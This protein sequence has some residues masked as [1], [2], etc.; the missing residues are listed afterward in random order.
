MVRL[1]ISRNGFALTDFC[2][3]V[4]GVMFWV[5]ELNKAEPTQLLVVLSA[6]AS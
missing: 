5:T 6:D 2:S 1:V 3:V 4:G